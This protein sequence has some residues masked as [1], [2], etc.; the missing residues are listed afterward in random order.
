VPD[1]RQQGFT[2]I[3]LMVALAVFSLAALAL[4]RLEGAT[5]SNARVLDDRLMGQVV[6]RNVAVDMLSDPAAPSVGMTKGEQDNGGRK[7]GWTRRT[8]TT[9]DPRILRVDINVTDDTGAN[10]AALTVVRRTT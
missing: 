7:W 8:A 5:L 4:L 1:R 9:D 2:L 6:A 10:V 3:E